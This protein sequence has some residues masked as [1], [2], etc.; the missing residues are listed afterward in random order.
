MSVFMTGDMW[1]V[2]DEVDY[3]VITTNAIIKRNGAVV[4]GAGIAKQMRDKY[5]GIG[6]GGLASWA[7]APLLQ[8][9]PDNVQIWTFK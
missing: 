9:L 5:P 2:F 6:N 4:M 7:V 8:N 1:R 3:F